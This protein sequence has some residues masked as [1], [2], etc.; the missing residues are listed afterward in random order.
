MC[1]AG[2]YNPLQAVRLP[3][4]EGGVIEAKTRGLFVI[5]G[6]NSSGKTLFLKDLEN[7]VLATGQRPIVCQEMY[8][9]KPGD[10]HS[11]VEHLVAQGLLQTAE[12]N[13]VKLGSPHL[14]TG[15]GG[16]VKFPLQNIQGDF[17]NKFA[18]GWMAGVTF[19]FL[20]TIGRLLVTSLFLENR[21]T[22]YSSVN[23]F[24]QYNQTP[25]NDLQALFM[26]REAQ[27]KL[28]AETGKVFGNVAWLDNVTFSNL[29]QLR[30]SGKPEPPPEKD[31]RTPQK[32]DS[33]RLL[34]QEGHGFKSYVGIVI[35]LLLGQRPVC[36][37]DE[38]EL[39][40]HPP[41]AYALG[42]FIGEYG[43]TEPHGVRSTKGAHLG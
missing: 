18:D 42:R 36:L 17:Y 11:F 10:L 8:L 39:C 13:Q 2:E 5:V 20:V 12:Q 24:D 26:N 32:V 37:I 27:D 21:L 23:R 38:P 16:N 14:G 3:R 6:P 34:E 7:A 22:L 19:D 40:L 4:P 1:G 30:A 41:Q 29:L 28:E 33:Y 25:Q 43:T 35:A 31:R 9:R 15:K